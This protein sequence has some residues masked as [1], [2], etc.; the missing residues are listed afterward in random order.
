MD[1]T[2]KS[3]GA[4]M[5]RSSCR[6][7][8]VPGAQALAS[9]ALA[10]AILGVSAAA[11]GALPAVPAGYTTSQFAAAPSGASNCDDITRLKANIFITCQNATQSTGGGGDSTIVEYAPDGSVVDTW[12]LPDKA[13]GIGADPRHHRVIVTLNEDGN[14]HLAT[15]TPGAPAGSQ[16]T[17]YSYSPGAPDSA[18]LMGSPLYTGGGTDSV[19]VGRDG[20]VYISAS[21]SN[22]TGTAVFRVVLTK[23][24]TPGGT[25]SAALNPTFLDN[26]AAANGNAGSGTAPLALTDVDSNAIV[27]PY[28]P[29]YAGQFVIDDQTSNQLVF[30][31]NIDAGTGLTA[32]TTTLG[33]QPTSLDDIRWA[34]DSGTLYVVD[35][36]PAGASVVDRVTGPFPRGTALAADGSGQVDTVDLGSGA[37]TSFATGFSSAKGL[38]FA[39][40]SQGRGSQGDQGQQ[41]A[42]DP[43]QQGHHGHGRS[44]GPGHGN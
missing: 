2:T 27:P 15:I 23:P 22:G 3:K 7:P 36:G 37:L 8:R 11:A 12:S 20:Q 4:Q 13:D 38:L 41:E 44:R 18:V 24:S 25:G 17:N 28:S 14:S 29:R 21:N 39:G 6:S 10:T 16:I 31:D 19:I 33:G 35:K 34:S 1:S 32:L 40:S 43:G 5:I 9:L 26:A 42:G 30:A